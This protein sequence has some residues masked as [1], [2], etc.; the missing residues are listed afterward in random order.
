[1]KKIILLLIMLAPLVAH[2]DEVVREKE[3]ADQMSAT[4]LGFCAGLHLKTAAE[5]ADCINK[6][7]D[8]ALRLLGQEKVKK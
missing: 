8:A 2:G 6:G 7:F 5:H 3:V 4:V 1:M